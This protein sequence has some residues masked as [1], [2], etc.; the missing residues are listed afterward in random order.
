MICSG[1]EVNNSLIQEQWAQTPQR[2]SSR[3]SPGSLLNEPTAHR[4]FGDSCGTEAKCQQ[5]H[6]F[7]HSSEFGG[8]WC[9]SEISAL[10]S[11]SWQLTAMKKNE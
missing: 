3:P 6:A 11:Q 8:Y 1:M 10:H 7:A 2:V 9:A 5:V 4:V